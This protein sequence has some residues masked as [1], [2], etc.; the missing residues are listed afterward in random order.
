M[1][2]AKARL[3]DASDFHDVHYRHYDTDHNLRLTYD[4]LLKFF[5]DLFGEIP[6]HLQSTFDKVKYQSSAT[7]GRDAVDIVRLMKLL[8]MLIV[9]EGRYHPSRYSPGKPSQEL[10][11][12]S[13]PIAPTAQQ[14]VHPPRIRD[15]VV[16]KFKRQKLLGKG[17]QGEVHLGTYDGIVCAGKTFTGKPDQNLVNEV[18]HEV[19]FFEKLDHPNCHYLL[20][21]KTTLDNGGVI[22]LTEVCEKGSFFDL[23]CTQKVVFDLPTSWRI[24]KECAQGYEYI[25]NLGYMHRDI[26]SL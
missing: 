21:A 7:Q 19:A 13:A 22:T 10:N 2:S 26:K 5:H 6:T 17:G 14:S 23:Y 3:P 8:Y 15:I 18:K 25:H 4:E 12:V 1:W 9:P 16:T 24:A 11:I 20:G